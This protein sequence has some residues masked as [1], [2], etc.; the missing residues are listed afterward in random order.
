[1]WMWTMCRWIW[2]LRAIME[3]KHRVFIRLLFSTAAQTSALSHTV[4]GEN[5]RRLETDYLGRKRTTD[6][7]FQWLNWRV[8]TRRKSLELSSIGWGSQ[9]LNAGGTPETHLDG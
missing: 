9:R 1:M 4:A 7:I 6:T 8:T 2:R 3:P 5:G